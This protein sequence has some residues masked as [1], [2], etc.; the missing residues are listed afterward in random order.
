VFCRLSQSKR[1]AVEGSIFTDNS[2]LSAKI[3]AGAHIVDRR[4]LVPILP[5][6]AVL[7]RGLKTFG[8]VISFCRNSCAA[9]ASA[10]VYPE[11]LTTPCGRSAQGGGDSALEFFFPAW[12]RAFVTVEE[13][14]GDWLYA[15]EFH[16]NCG[17]VIHKVFLT[18]ES[19]FE[20]F[21]WW[22]E[23]N[24]AANPVQDLFS[25]MRRPFRIDGSSAPREGDVCLLTGRDFPALL[26]AMIECEISVRISVGNEGLVQR[27]RM[28]PNRLRDD[29]ACIYLGDGDSGS[30]R[31]F[32]N[33]RAV[34]P[35]GS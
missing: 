14:A 8:E 31:C 22:V 19:D 35:I 32:F 7:F 33:D 23:M 5:R 9:L 30:R 2:L 11:V 15:V 3:L 13:K 27:A 21:R 28:R 4:A 29:G 25:K 17:D 18:S 1:A 20:A 34:P 16:D 6:W 24:H 12:A 10:G 26:R